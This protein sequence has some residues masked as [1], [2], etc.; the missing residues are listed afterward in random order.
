MKLPWSSTTI[1]N[2]TNK[3]LPFYV[4]RVYCDDCVAYA[5]LQYFAGAL[6]KH[7]RDIG[8]CDNFAVIR[9]AAD[10][11]QI[12]IFE[13]ASV[14]VRERETANCVAEQGHKYHKSRQYWKNS[15][16]IWHATHI[17]IGTQNIQ[18]F[19]AAII[20]VCSPI[21]S[22]KMCVAI[23]NE[24]GMHITSKRSKLHMENKQNEN[25]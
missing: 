19:V 13:S 23:P 15:C 1:W 16:S 10:S 3:N 24:N 21:G 18:V 25:V 2:T 14:R 5:I 20:V 4:L 7:H 6:K 11:I 8:E 12:Y 9:H 17:R 22:P